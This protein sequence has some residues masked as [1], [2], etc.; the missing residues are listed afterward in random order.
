MKPLNAFI[1]QPFRAEHSVRFR[2]LVTEVCNSM[3]GAFDS[4]H[5]IG[6]PSSQPRLQDRINGYLKKADLCIADLAGIRN[7]NALLEVGAAYALGIPVIPFSDKE[8][9]ADIRGNLYAKVD[10][11]R[12]GEPQVE[13]EFRTTLTRRLLEA[14]R[15]IGTTKN[16]SYLSHGYEDRGV[17]DFYSLINRCEK[18]LY[19]LTTNLNYIIAVRLKVE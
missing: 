6:E 18:R 7:E 19:I 12:L 3:A 2:E 1:I 4:F 17:V 10:L 14:R 11:P 5:P 15:E 16:R 13:S 8:L 9:P